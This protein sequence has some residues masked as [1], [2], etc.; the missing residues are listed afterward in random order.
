M[1][2]RFVA[3]MVGAMGALRQKGLVNLSVFGPFHIQP[4]NSQRSSSGTIVKPLSKRAH[5][6]FRMIV[7]EKFVPRGLTYGR[8]SGGKGTYEFATDSKRTTNFIESP[9][10]RDDFENAIEELVRSGILAGGGTLVYM[11]F[12]LQEE[13]ARDAVILEAKISPKR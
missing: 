6:L 3:F 10:E 12:R 13:A 4:H 11:S 5:E 9:T 1:F 2:K 8:L 7:K